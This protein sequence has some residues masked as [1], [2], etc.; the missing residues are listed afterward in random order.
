VN[1]FAMPVSTVVAP[2]TL[3]PG[4]IRPDLHAVTIAETT[5]PLALVSCT[6][7]EGVHGPLL[8]LAVRIVN[9]V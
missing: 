8:T 6:R 3:I 1:E 7:L 5:D 2:L 4:A 9:L